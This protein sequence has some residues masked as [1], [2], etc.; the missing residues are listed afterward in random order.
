MLLA[1]V[2]IGVVVEALWEYN[3]ARAP[4]HSRCMQSAAALPLPGVGAAKQSL[5][6][7]GGGEVHTVAATGQAVQRSGHF[8]AAFPVYPSS[9]RGGSRLRCARSHHGPSLH[10]RSALYGLLVQ[11]FVARAAKPALRVPRV[12]WLLR[13]HAAADVGD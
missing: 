2:P 7:Q 9:T 6:A 12:A 8:G 3:V 11:Q 5:T 10:V 4:S 1:A 13:G